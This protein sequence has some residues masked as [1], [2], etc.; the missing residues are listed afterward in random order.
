MASKLSKSEREFYIEQLRKHNILEIDG[1]PVQD[2]K[3]Y[4]LKFALT[5]ERIKAG[6]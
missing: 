2:L 1:V 6:A 3:D 5:M 4:E